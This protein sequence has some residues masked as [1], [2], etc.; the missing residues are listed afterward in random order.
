M[1]L[2]P[3]HIVQ[4]NALCR[5]DENSGTAEAGAIVRL[6][7]ENKLAAITS[8]SGG[9]PYALLAQRVKAQAA[10]LP[11]NF[12]FPGEIGNSDAHVGDPVLCFQSGGI[13][14]TTHYL[15]SGSLA[16]GAPLYAS[17]TQGRLTNVSASG[18]LEG[19]VPK[20]CAIAQNSLSAAQAAAG[21]N[22]VIKLA[23]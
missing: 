21:E 15:V 16:A 7:G 11:Q 23:L 4:E 1:A 19:G 17:A 22:L 14:E 5:H 8:I 6:S 2:T 10:G 20:V 9:A 18:A 12:Q 3:R 13:F